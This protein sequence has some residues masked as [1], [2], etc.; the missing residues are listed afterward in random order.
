MNTQSLHIGL[1]IYGSLDELTGGYLYDRKLVEYLR[2]CG[3]TV[4]V[5][6]QRSPAGY[7]RSLRQNFFG[8]PS[9]THISETIDVLLQDELNHPSLILWNRRL[10]REYSGPVITIVHALRCR[11]GISQPARIL[12]QTLERRYLKSVDGFVAVSRRTRRHIHQLLRRD[13]PG[14]VA[15]P[16]GDRFNSLSQEAPPSAG[17]GNDPLHVLFAGNLSANKQL[18]FLLRALASLPGEDYILTVVGDLDFDPDYATYVKKWIDRWNLAELITF[19]GKIEDPEQM[20]RRYREADVLV[21]PSRSEGFPLVIP[22]AAGFSVPAIATTHSAADEFIDHGVN[23]YLCQ[24]DDLKSLTGSLQ[25]LQS[26]RQTLRSMGRKALEQFHRH[27]TWDETGE[28]VH[29][30]IQNIHAHRKE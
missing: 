28:R 9:V 29:S 15:Y 12:A 26:D 3:H 24:P 8:E 13:K 30:F 22:E 1:I 11:S 23:G 10:K 21:L 16:G 18:H 5:F 14:V 25:S 27:P 6:G 4:T 17:S 2:R 7:L 20:A 19:T